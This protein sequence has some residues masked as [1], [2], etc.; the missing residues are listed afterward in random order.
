M[1]AVYRCTHVE[2]GAPAAVKTLLPE[3][4]GLGDAVER[5][6]FAREA[7]AMAQL[8]HPHL[9][10]VHA[11]SLAGATPWVAQ[12]LL[13]GGSLQDRLTRQGPLPVDEAVALAIKL[14]RGVAHAHSRGVLHR[15]I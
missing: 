1:G 14:A 6:R 7:E 10:A 12:D 9:V 3:G 2:T 13:P 4:L 5:A 8:D 11:A 15:D